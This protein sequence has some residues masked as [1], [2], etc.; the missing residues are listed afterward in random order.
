MLKSAQFLSVILTFAVLAGCQSTSEMTDQLDPTTGLHTVSNTVF[1]KFSLAKVEK[2]NKYKAIYF[3]PL[4][5]NQLEIDTRQLDVGD[6]NWSLS[7]T[8][9]SKIIGY[10]AD[11]VVSSAQNSPLPL[12]RGPGENVL[13]ATF[14]LTRFAPAAPKDDSRSARTEIFTY[15]VG[16][17]EMIGILTDSV[18]GE[19]MGSI[20]DTQ[21]VGDTVYLEK[22][23]RVNNTR[24]LKNTFQ[25]WTDGL[26]ATLN[27]LNVK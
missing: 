12:A 1:D 9:K 5:L 18:S 16:N 4:N 17:L 14:T 22:N 3:E 20:E 23:D 21:A 7:A 26:M 19:V 15:N 24:K 25:R 10:F 2:L 6:R 27:E 8:E 11:S 13:T